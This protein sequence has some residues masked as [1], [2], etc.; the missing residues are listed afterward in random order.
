MMSG[1]PAVVGDAALALRCNQAVDQRRPARVRGPR[2]RLH[3][4]T[5]IARLGLALRGI[6]R[7]IDISDGLLADLGHICERSKVAAV[8]EWDSVPVSLVMRNQVDR[9]SGDGGGARGGD[10]YELCFTCA[11]RRDAVERAGRESR[12][13]VTRIGR[14]VRAARGKAPVEVV[15]MA[16]QSITVRRKG[17]DHFS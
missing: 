16:G 17:Y 7:A 4:P 9:K 11:R 13:A 5:R 12:V 2:S 10:D 15:D 1:C 8:I 14:V 6:A 3:A